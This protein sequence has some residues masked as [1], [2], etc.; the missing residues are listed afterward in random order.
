[1]CIRDRGL[2]PR[3]ADVFA[4]MARGRSLPYIAE[5]LVLSENTIRSHT[6]RI[7]NKLGV[8]SKQEM[9]DLLGQG[10]KTQ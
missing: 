6:R 4:L 9:L 3:E 5:T 2:S 10:E 8:H 1:M 7:Y